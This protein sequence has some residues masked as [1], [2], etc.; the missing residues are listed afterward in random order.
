[1]KVQLPVT[2]NN[3]YSFL[4][5]IV[6]HGFGNLEGPYHKDYDVESFKDDVKRYPW[7]EMF[8]TSDS[9]FLV[10]FNMALMKLCHYDPM[11]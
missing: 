8:D 1:M 2:C 11:Y 5:G 4:V 3:I 10:N 6:E 9:E 7:D